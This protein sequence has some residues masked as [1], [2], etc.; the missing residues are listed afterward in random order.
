MPH[1]GFMEDLEVWEVLL[2]TE[3]S[4]MG[5]TIDRTGEPLHIMSDPNTERTIIH[6][7]R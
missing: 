7:T 3:E 1:S 2:T 5:R 4:H 6:E